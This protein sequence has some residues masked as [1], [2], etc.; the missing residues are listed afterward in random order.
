MR[1]ITKIKYIKSCQ[2]LKYNT[3]SDKLVYYFVIYMSPLLAYMAMML[4][5]VSCSLGLRW[6]V[7]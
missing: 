4:L 3:D 7:K 6:G 5:M 1:E 2:F